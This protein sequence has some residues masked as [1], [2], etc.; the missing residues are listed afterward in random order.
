MNKYCQW[1]FF[2]DNIKSS[3]TKIDI[4]LFSTLS[5]NK[6]TI[7]RTINI[8]QT[9]IEQLDFTNEIINSKIN[10]IYND[11]FTTR[12]TQQTIF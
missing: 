4:V 2:L 6:R 11:L 5:F 8:F 7:I 10:K 1:L 3:L 12:N 9:I